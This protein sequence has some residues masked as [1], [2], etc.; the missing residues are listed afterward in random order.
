MNKQTFDA[1][2]ALRREK[3]R[4]EEQIA[5][6]RS[7]ALRDFAMEV[8]A[9]LDEHGCN[10]NDLLQVWGMFPADLRKAKPRRTVTA[11]RLKTDHSCT[12]SG[13]GPF[14][15]KLRDSMILV[16]L[17]PSKKDDRAAFFAEYMEPI[18][19][20]TSWFDEDAVEAAVEE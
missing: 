19:T 3:N 4:L 14:P 12:Y 17:D 10:R 7:N 18:P 1:V 15:H 2:A 6:A 16:G 13:R 8:D 20:E 9:A 5:K 11:L